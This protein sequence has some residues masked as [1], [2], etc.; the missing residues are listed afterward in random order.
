MVE[1]SNPVQ[2]PKLRNLKKMLFFSCEVIKKMATLSNFFKICRNLSHINMNLTQKC[3]D[4]S[5]HTFHDNHDF[6]EKWSNMATLL[7]STFFHIPSSIYVKNCHSP[8]SSR[9]R[10]KI[11]EIFIFE[12]DIHNI[13]KNSM[14][15]VTL[16]ESIFL[17]TGSLNFV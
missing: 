5:T 9:S 16:L 1:I 4:W 11:P 7:I 3:E 14:N 6:M 17:D 12:H 15:I 10:K 2:K 13:M 8:P